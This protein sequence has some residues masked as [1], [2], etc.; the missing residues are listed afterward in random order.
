MIP[1]LLLLLFLPLIGA[2]LVIMLPKSLSSNISK[3]IS[4]LVLVMAAITA[5]W[6]VQ[7]GLS[8]LSISYA[9]ISQLNVNLGL[10]ISQITLILAVMTSVIFF[11]ASFVGDY[12][13]GRNDKL[14]NSIFL[15]IEMST[16]GVFLSSN[17]FLFYLFWEISEIAMFFIIFL[18]GG[19][20]RRYASI[21]FI[22]YSIFSSLLLLIGIMLLYFYSAPHTF[23][24][25]VLEG[26]T[27]AMPYSIQILT[28]LLLL[29]G[30]MVKVPVF[31]LHSWLPDAHTEAPAP[32]SMI[33]A[34]VLLKF[35]GY[36]L[37]LTFLILHSIASSYAI[38]IAILFAFS[39]IYGAMVALRKKNMK[40]LIA[41]T[42]IA[43][44]G[45]ISFA[46]IAMNQFGT[47]GATYAMLAHGLAISM[48]FM[49]AG[50]F[51]KEYGTLQIEGITGVAKWSGA[52]AFF[53][54]FG[55]FAAIGI[56]LTAGF[57]G[58]V[59]LFMGSVGAFG[60]FG[61]VPALAIIIVGAYLFWVI[62]R[63]IFGEQKGETYNSNMDKAVIVAA[64]ILAASAVLFGI[65]PVLINL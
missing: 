11:A 24:I 17:F 29:V 19:V 65:V 42:S 51:D 6:S 1:L 30:F 35:G 16:I 57:I 9:Y 28:F 5:Y 22:M 15:L 3:I 43:D 26:G 4:G 49:L 37:I 10:S 62:E 39:A 23:S 45:I 38:Y 64:I 61:L 50:M 27:L 40:R 34:G 31:P 32:G 44:M 41:F 25:A 54:V 63:S 18:Y 2:L 14:Y 48:L 8:S 21:K 56:P 58:D 36:G 33:L 47:L 59:V 46:I 55:V 13:I 52:A 12:F 20:D 7:Y 60:I 53:F